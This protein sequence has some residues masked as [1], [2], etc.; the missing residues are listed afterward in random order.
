MV[1]EVHTCFLVHYQ[2]QIIIISSKNSVIRQVYWGLQK[3][4]LNNVFCK[5]DGDFVSF[6]GYLVAHLFIKPWNCV[7]LIHISTGWVWSW[8][9]KVS[10]FDFPA[11][12]WVGR[13]WQMI[14]MGIYI[15]ILS[16]VKSSTQIILWWRPYKNLDTLHIMD[17]TS[18]INLVAVLGRWMRESKRARA[19]AGMS[20]IWSMPVHLE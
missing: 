18:K 9:T 10:L 13:S 16:C 4:R 7:V 1:P 2:F 6:Q 15:R 17:H 19:E 11:G 12:K 14:F 5:T 20:D 8:W 3:S